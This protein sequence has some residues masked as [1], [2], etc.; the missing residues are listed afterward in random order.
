MPMRYNFIN[1]WRQ[2][3]AHYSEKSICNQLNWKID[4]AGW[5]RSTVGE[6]LKGKECV[7]VVAFDP[8]LYTKAAN[9]FLEGTFSEVDGPKW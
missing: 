3:R 5:F 2:E 4:F 1:L 8:F 7:C 9:A 6:G